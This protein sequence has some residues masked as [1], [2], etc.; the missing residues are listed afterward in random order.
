MPQKAGGMKTVAANTAV[1]LVSLL[2]AVIFCEIGARF[3]LNPANYLSATTVADPVLGMTIEPHAAGFDSW[4]FRNPSVP[5]SVDVLALGDSHTYGNTAKMEDAWP[6]VVQRATGLSVYNMGLGGYGPN[7]YYQLFMTRGVT[8]HPRYV[9]VGLYMGDDFENAFSITYGLDHWA[10]LRD[11]TRGPVNADIWGDVEAPTTFKSFRNWLSQNSI[12]YRLVVHGPALAALKAK[13]QFGQVAA[14]RDAS[15]TVLDDS[16][17]NIHEAFRPIRVAAGLDQQ[18]AEVRE[19]MRI[20]FRLLHEMNQTCQRAGCS[21]IVVIIPSKETVFAD[22]F[23][24]Q[25]ELHL[26]SVVDSLIL[27]ERAARSEVGQFLTQAGIPYVDTLPALRQSIRDK[28]YY[29]GPADMHPSAN[30]YRVIGMA[31]AEFLRT[32]RARAAQQ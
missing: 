17:S 9:V 13:L 27:N 25:T 8:L 3:V 26:K 10:F 14:D 23:A 12:V 18:R 20:T 11:G 31:V 28:L 1:V 4:G 15:V 24:R 21:L 5:S 6:A 30:G 19:G 2:I 22:Y 29:P 16:Q 32:S 7:Q